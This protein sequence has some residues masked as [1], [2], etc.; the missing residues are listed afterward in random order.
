[1]QERTELILDY[2]RGNFPFMLELPVTTQ[3][4]LPKRRQLQNTKV[5][6]LWLHKLYTC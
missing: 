1:M 6:M 5:L 4:L 2:A 3:H